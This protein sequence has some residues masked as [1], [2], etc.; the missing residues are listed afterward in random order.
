[1]CLYSSGGSCSVMTE[2]T[3]VFYWQSN[4]IDYRPGFAVM[5]DIATKDK[6]VLWCT[7]GLELI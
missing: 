2:D 6:N 7:Q 5:W 3:G 1:M 4:V